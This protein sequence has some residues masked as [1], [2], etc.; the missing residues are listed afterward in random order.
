MVDVVRILCML[1]SQSVGSE[2]RIHTWGH[3][4]R[5]ATAVI[6]GNAVCG[7]Q[8]KV[9]ELD[10]TALVGDQD[11]LRLQVPMIDSHGMTKLNS[12]QDLKEGMFGKVV[13]SDKAALLC[14]VGE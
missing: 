5:G 2:S 3:I 8:A 13:V 12:I 1:A 10:G 4:E 9:G 6:S 11:I 7:S 14:D